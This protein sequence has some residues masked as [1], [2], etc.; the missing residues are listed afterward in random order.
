V[1]LQL[2]PS[3]QAIGDGG[4]CGSKGAFHG[5]TSL[6]R[7]LAPGSLVRGEMANP[8][9][10][11][12]GCPVLATGLTPLSSV[13]LLRRTLWHPTMHSWCTQRQRMCVLALLV[14]ELR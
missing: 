4:I 12:A 6:A 5:C 1:N 3:L 11:F 7:L 9:K 2:P 14:A 8:T 10:V 13:R